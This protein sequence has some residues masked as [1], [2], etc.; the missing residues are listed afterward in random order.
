MHQEFDPQWVIQYL[1]YPIF[2][3]ERIKE[4]KIIKIFYHIPIEIQVE[5]LE[6]LPRLSFESSLFCKFD[7][8]SDFKLLKFIP[9]E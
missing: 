7:F 5:E 9:G 3:N 1:F 8:F 2:L 4:Y 6:K